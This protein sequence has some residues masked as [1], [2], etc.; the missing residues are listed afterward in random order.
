MFHQTT[1][2]P[3]L[4]WRFKPWTPFQHNWFL[5]QQTLPIYVSTREIG[6]AEIEW[7]LKLEMSNQIRTRGA[8]SHRAVCLP[9]ANIFTS[10]FLE[11]ILWMAVAPLKAIAVT[12]V[13]KLAV[14]KTPWMPGRW[15]WQWNS[16]VTVG[17]SVCR[18]SIREFILDNDISHIGSHISIYMLCTH[19][20]KMWSEYTTYN[21]SNPNM[22]VVYNR[23]H[24]TLK[25]QLC[26]W[27]DGGMV[28]LLWKLPFSICSKSLL[29]SR[30]IKQKAI[31]TRVVRRPNCR[32]AALPCSNCNT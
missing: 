5:M 17:I 18:D 1:S 4:K 16:K 29:Q 32:R 2:K 9:G 7:R 10:V 11:T 19:L 3:R 8:R 6:T 23:F 26:Q 14:E 28:S 31:P 22:F 27:K 21:L 12:E 24:I 25:S 20:N 30:R 15:L 13:G